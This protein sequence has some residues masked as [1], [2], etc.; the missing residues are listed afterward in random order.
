MVIPISG[1]VLME[2][3]EIMR[4]KVVTVAPDESATAAWTRMRRRGIRHLVVMNDGQL[5]GVLSERDLGGRT[6]AERRKGRRV[7]DLMTP[8]VMSVSPDTTLEEAADLMRARL[9]GS[10]P[11]MEE[12]RLAGLVTATD[13]FESLGQEA[14][15]RM[16]RAE[17]ELLRAPASSK[18]LGGRPIARSRPKP[19]RASRRTRAPQD[20]KKEPFAD[21]VPRPQK[22]VAGRT[23]APLV[24]AN[25]RMSGVALDDATQD[26]IR[27]RLGRKLGKFARAIERVSVRVEDVNGPR[28]G[29]DREARIKV[30]LSGLPSVVVRQQAE[31]LDPAINGAVASAER[32]VR[33]AVQ[34]RRTEPRKRAARGAREV[35]PAG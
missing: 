22:R 13:V 2:L 12:D 25:I 24:P 27:K 1:S 3:R 4:T 7:R 20:L 26:G 17:R 34:R 9:I 14:V 6:G 35:V 21:R 15:S 28:G 31:T 16:S 30:V 18:S 29:V 32:A 33:R 23:P 5:A 19:E 8:T 11:I 10:L